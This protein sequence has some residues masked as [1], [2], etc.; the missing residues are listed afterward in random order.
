MTDVITSDG[1]LSADRK[2]TLFI[3]VDMMIPEEGVMPSAADPAIFAA[4]LE[5]LTV[6]E[7]A[8]SSLLSVIEDLSEKN[9]ERSF[10]RLNDDERAVVI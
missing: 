5:Q 9:H 6:D 1:L 10:A 7:V 8:L 4:I 2:S 3:L